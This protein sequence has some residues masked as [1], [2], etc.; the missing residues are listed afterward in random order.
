VNTMSRAKFILGLAVLPIF[1]I[2]QAAFGQESAT[3][4]QAQPQAPN[5]FELQAQRQAESQAQF[6]SEPQ[7]QAQ[8]PVNNET[9]VNLPVQSTSQTQA[10]IQTQPN[11]QTQAGQPRQ[12]LLDNG[13]YVPADGVIDGTNVKQFL[14]SGPDVN[15]TQMEE[16]SIQADNLMQMPDSA[17]KLQK[18]GKKK[19]KG[20][21]SSIGQSFASTADFLGFPLSNVDHDVDASLSSDLPKE[22]RDAYGSTDPAAH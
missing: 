1:G 15:A 10:N 5:A 12:R 2:S 6:S 17:P 4:V 13:Q 14:N 22:V 9:S 18:P 3:Q 21:F 7:T 16:A 20:F 8:P 19:K 11:N